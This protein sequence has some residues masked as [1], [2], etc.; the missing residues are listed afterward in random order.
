MSVGERIFLNVRECA[1][2]TR[3][4]ATA[5]GRSSVEYLDVNQISSFLTVPILMES[6]WGQVRCVQEY[7]DK[8]EGFGVFSVIQTG[9][10]VIGR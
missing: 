10:L 4:D 3:P 8:P 2:V 5:M 1:V 7:L 9:L 6:S